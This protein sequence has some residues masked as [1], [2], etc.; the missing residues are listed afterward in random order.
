MRAD[1]ACADR[2]SHWRYW[3]Y[4]DEAEVANPNAAEARQ[5][6]CRVVG[7]GVRIHPG[8]AHMSGR[9]GV[10]HVAQYIACA[11]LTLVVWQ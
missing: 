4:N 8:N 10:Q 11:A 7:G 2:K 3:S 9:H 1:L 5:C 6:L